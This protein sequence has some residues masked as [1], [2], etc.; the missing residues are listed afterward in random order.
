MKTLKRLLAEL[1]NLFPDRYIHMGSDETS[2]GGKCTHE[3]SYCG[4]QHHSDCRLIYTGTKSLE[5]EVAKY[6]LSL[7]RVPIAWE[8]ALLDSGVVS[9]VALMYVTQPDLWAQNICTST[10]Y[11][12]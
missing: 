2:T 8:E 11:S 10:Y 4:V 1:V 7:G 3:G 5:T 12:T 6:I 9:H